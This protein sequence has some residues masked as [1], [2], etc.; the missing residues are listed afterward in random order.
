M[1]TFRDCLEDMPAAD[2]GTFPTPLEHMP[3]L[4]RE[5]GH[6]G[7]YVKRDDITGLSL[8]GNKTRSLRFLLGQALSL[9][10]DTVITAGGLQSNLCSLTAAACSKLGLECILIHNDEPPAHLQGNMLL[11]RIFGAREIFV[12]RVSEE[13]RAE[14]ME[15]EARNLERLGKRPHLIHNGAST[16]MGALGYVEAA[17]ELHEQCNGLG[18]D[19]KHVFIVGA[20]GGTA[21]GFAYGTG[22]LGAPFHVYVVSVEYPKA[23]LMRRMQAILSGLHEILPPLDGAFTEALLQKLVTIDDSHLGEGYARP[24]PASRAA[25]TMAARLEGL[26]IEDVYTSKTLAG[27]IGSVRS[28]AIPPHEAACFI[29]TGG[30]GSL[31]AQDILG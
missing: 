4:G 7:L 31:F 28:G 12:G 19:L 10:K 20:M 30:A 22:L 21:S 15:N 17:F 5:I 9:G 29:H 16:P 6:P 8:G 24:T 2:I 1:A 13:V 25:L 26:L 14:E 11:N 27:M 3:R 18:I 23:E